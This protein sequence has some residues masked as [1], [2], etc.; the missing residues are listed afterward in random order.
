MEVLSDLP[1]ANGSV[2]QWGGTGF[3]ALIDPAGPDE[4]ATQIN[5]SNVGNIGRVLCQKPVKWDQVAAVSWVGLLARVRR[6][7]IGGIGGA[8]APQVHRAGSTFEAAGMVVTS[9]YADY[10]AR[11]LLSWQCEH[12]PATGDFWTLDNALAAEVG[13]RDTSTDDHLLRWTLAR[14]LIAVQWKHGGN[15]VRYSVN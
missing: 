1:V 11:S 14:K 2:M 5:S 7:P 6:V 12:D 4:D 10:D 8:I 13:L 9:A 15:A 3:V